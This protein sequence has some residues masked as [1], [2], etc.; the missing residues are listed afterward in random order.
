M[1]IPP[2]IID[3]NSPIPT[4]KYV[5]QN[6]KSKRIVNC[7]ATVNIDRAKITAVMTI[8]KISLVIFF[9]NVRQRIN[10]RNV[11]IPPIGTSSTQVGD[12]KFASTTPK[13]TATI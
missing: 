11:E 10:T 12:I 8:F 1:T 4:V 7:P 6:G 13:V 2:T 5:G 3:S 9:V